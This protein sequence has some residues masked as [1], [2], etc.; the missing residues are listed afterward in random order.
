MNG[1]TLDS[2]IETF[3]RGS[4]ELG[5]SV[6]YGRYTPDFLPSESVWAVA[7]DGKTMLGPFELEGQYVFTRYN[8]IE[9]VARGFP[10]A[11]ANREFSA[12][13]PLEVTVEFELA[14]LAD[15][16]HGYWADLR[17]R[18]FPDV[19]RDTPLGRPFANPQFVL[20]LRGEQVWLNG[21]VKEVDSA[22]LRARAHGVARVQQDHLA[23]RVVGAQ[24]QHLG[25]ERTDLLGREVDDGH[26]QAPDQLG[27]PVVAGDLGAGALDPQ[28]AEVN[29]QLVR[30]TASLGKL[31]G[32]DHEAD[33]HVDLLE[34]GPADQRA[35]RS[36]VVRTAPG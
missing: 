11:V 3:A 36:S 28:R 30:R 19:L 17:Y 7:R 5:A 4:S 10:A 16:K 22:D 33:A 31:L 32:V 20:T 25:D 26:H 8:G 34:V 23:R 1:V 9:H 2:S 14:G 6:Y 29:P 27:D 13:T 15:T 18:F 24:H 35:A 12:G 21:L